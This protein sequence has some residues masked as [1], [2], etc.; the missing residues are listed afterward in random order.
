MDSKRDIRQ[1]L[2]IARCVVIKVGTRVLV[3]S[4]GRPQLARIRQLVRQIAAIQSQGRRVIL[5]SSGAIGTGVESLGLPGRPKRLPELQM[6]AAVGQVRLMA[7]YEELFAKH[8]IKIAQLLLTHDDLKN[9][10]RH[11]NVRNTLFALLR[12]NLV[13][14]LNENDVVSVD[15]LKIGDNDVLAS[16]VAMLVDADALVLLTTADGLRAPTGGRQSRRVKHLS[17]VTPEALALAV[18]KG[19]GLSTGGMSTK[20]QAARSVVKA[21]K[22]VVIADGRKDDVLPRVFSGADEGTL[23]GG[24]K[25]RGGIISKGRKRWIAFFHR[26]QGSIIVDD[27]AA[28]AIERRG[29]SL[30]PIGVRR[31]EGDFEVGSPVNIMRE[32]GT[33]IARGLVQ[34]SSQHVRLIRGQRSSEIG[35]ILGAVG[36]EEVIHRDNMVLLDHV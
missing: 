8:K 13:P 12:N 2:L 11:L 29:K 16:L 22:L 26:T 30:L 33:V 7:R 9:R 5:V 35:K 27:G 31:V 3:N 34:Y 28:D 19:S 24:D 18:G 4:R 10:S 14:I 25:T 17:T 21:G 36:H 1:Q 32:D 20:L 6:A 23:I 15:S